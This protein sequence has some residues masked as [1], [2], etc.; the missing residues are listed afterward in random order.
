MNIKSLILLAFCLCTFSAFAQNSHSIKGITIDTAAKSKVSSTITILRPDSIMQ[1]FGYAGSDGS[2]TISGLPAGK[3]VLLATF[4][5]YADFSQEFT[6]SPTE[7]VHDFGNIDMTLLAKILNEAVI[8]GSIN[9]LKIKGDTSE[10]N[11]KAFVIQPNAKVDDLLKQIPGMEIDQNGNIKFRGEAIKKIT[12]DGEEFFSDDPVLVSRT[13]RGDMIDKV[14]VFDKRS[15]QA[16][17]TGVDDG[18]RTKTINLKLKED[19]KVGIFGKVDLAGGRSSDERG[20]YSGQVQFNRFRANE[21]FSLYGTM[22]NTGKVNLS[23]SDASNLGTQNLTALGDGV[24]LINGISDEFDNASFNGRGFPTAKTGGVHYDV[25][26]NEGKQLINTN[27]RIGSIANDLFQNTITDLLISNQTSNRTNNSSESHTS[28][29]RQKLD[30][31]YQKNTTTTNLRVNVDAALRNNESLTSSNSFQVDQDDKFVNRS[32]TSNNS[33]SEARLFNAS[34]FYSKKFAKPRR[35]ISWNLAENYSENKVERYAKTNIEY[36]NLPGNVVDQYKPERSTSSVLSSNITYTEPLAEKLTLTFNYLLG[37]NNSISRLES[38]NKSASGVY[39]QIDELTTNDYKY[40]ILTNQFGAT[41]GYVNAKT[42]LTFGTRASNV[43]F[44]QVDERRMRT[45]K[46]SYLNWM[47]QVNYQYRITPAKTISL[48]YNGN[49]QQP[50]LSQIQPVVNNLNPLYVTVG[51]PDLK[52][53]FTH[54]ARMFYSSQSTLSGSS[55][56]ISGNYSFTVNP[57]ISSISFNA[58]SGKTTTR[59]VNLTDKTPR[60]YSVSLQIGRKI[61]P[62]EM[63]IYPQF[64]FSGNTSYTYTS[65]AGVIGLNE[66]NGN[67]FSAGL[68]FSKSKAKKYSLNLSGTLNANRNRNSFTKRSDYSAMGASIFQSGTVYLP[69]RFEVFSSTRYSYTGPSNGFGGIHRTIWDASISRTFLKG[70][71]LKVSISGNN[72][73]DQ[74]QNTRGANGN[75][76]T[77]TSY[78]VIKRYFMLNLIWDFTKFGTLPSQN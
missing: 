25:K 40:T 28:G 14:Q 10:F 52:P 33:T 41:F 65:E 60:N 22:A 43:N 50:S 29:F 72:L 70:N 34:V 53:F 67:T 48:N 74:N 61:V 18:Q 54:S 55:F 66:S 68:Q 59:F 46:R 71:N 19:K 47:P 44:N 1:A 64:S 8:K 24:F 7:P 37:I 6:I 63:N 17:F 56:S 5:E 26:W 11:A 58:D 62:W 32:A 38:Y 36:A 23:F 16:T 3:Y 15:D 30:V 69:G 78:N 21:K 12:V 73:L 45:M 20:M 4:P 27:Y 42:N 49:M 31:G 9:A 57:I 2:F 39:D 13:L 77:Q 35:T 75:T 51:N 76:I